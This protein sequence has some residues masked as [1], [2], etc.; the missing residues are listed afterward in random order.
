LSVNILKRGALILTLL[1]G[2]LVFLVVLALY[3]PASWFAGKLPPQVRCAKLGGSVWHGECLGL[4]VEGAKFGDATWNLSPLAA[5]TG[6]MSGDLDVR[7]G[8]LTARANLDMRFDGSG[9]LTDLRTQFPMDP[10]FMPQFPR[11]QRG[12]IVAQFSRL[13]V[14]A[15]GAPL[16]LEGSIELRDFQEVAPRLLELGSYRL[17]FDGKAQADGATMGRLTDIGGPFAVD[18]TVTF[19]PPNNY[20]VNGFITGRTAQAESIVRDITLG[21]RPDASGRSQFSFEGSF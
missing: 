16:Q 1:A 4:T 7:G 6:R 9:E 12:L 13:I 10:A 15:G 11:N 17:V 18:G 8:A 20:L 2:T 21:A 5:L 3:L 14:A 19:T